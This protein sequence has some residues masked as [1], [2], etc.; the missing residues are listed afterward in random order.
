M[1]NDSIDNAS[2]EDGQFVDMAELASSLASDG[3]TPSK[4][5][6]M[7][8]SVFR[9]VFD[10]VVWWHANGDLIPHPLPVENG[11]N[12]IDLREYKQY[13][14]MMNMFAAEEECAI[15]ERQQCF[16]YLRPEFVREHAHAWS[17]FKLRMKVNVALFVTLVTRQLIWQESS[18]SPADM[19]KAAE[20]EDTLLLSRSHRSEAKKLI[21]DST[22][23]LIT[24]INSN[25]HQ[26]MPAAA[27]LAWLAV[28]HL[29][30]GIGKARKIRTRRAKLDSTTLSATAL[31]TCIGILTFLVKGVTVSLVY[32]AGILKRTW[33]GSSDYSG[34][35][36]LSSSHPPILASS[37]PRLSSIQVDSQTR[38]PKSQG[39]GCPPRV[40]ETT[41]LL[42]EGILRRCETF[43]TKDVQADDRRA[44]LDGQ[45]YICASLQDRVL[46]A[47][48]TSTKRGFRASYGPSVVSPTK[49]TR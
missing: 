47:E 38:G 37:H 1:A 43:G 2:N 36:V 7:R 4:F 19:K 49:P 33:Y 8:G 29:V 42:K 21:V 31:A 35:G 6:G 34:S 22:A 39:H 5:E 28:Q 25:R 40:R 16:E 3:G 10:E 15:E 45:R 30:R 18:S 48:A 14:I 27:S 12:L 32:M 17:K 9:K 13:H 20:N 23:V 26:Q 44:Y 46:V 11:V 24:Y 41:M